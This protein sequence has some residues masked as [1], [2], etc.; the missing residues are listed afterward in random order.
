MVEPT[1]FKNISQMGSFSQVAVN[2]D[3]IIK[4]FETHHLD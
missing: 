4:T 3:K 2:I 1:H